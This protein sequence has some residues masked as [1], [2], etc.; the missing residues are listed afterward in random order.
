MKKRYYLL[1]GILFIFF[2]LVFPYIFFKENIAEESTFQIKEEPI[3]KVAGLGLVPG[4]YY[5]YRVETVNQSAN[6]S[7]LI[8]VTPECLQIIIVGDEAVGTCI[9]PDGSDSSGYNFTLENQMIAVYKPWMLAVNEEWEWG[10]SINIG[11][12]EIDKITFRGKGKEKVLGRDAYRVEITQGETVIT[13]WIDAKK[14]ILLYEEGKD[15]N[16][17][18]VE[19]PFTLQPQGG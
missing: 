8:G 9:Y 17:T 19:A 16:V 15:Y 3:K 14:R 18:L 1:A 2:L 5:E 10:V 6:I 7:Y 13:D 11:S 12:T 4:E